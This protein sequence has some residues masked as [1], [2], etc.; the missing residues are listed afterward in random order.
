MFIS[1]QLC[2]QDLVNFH[3]IINPIQ[4]WVVNLN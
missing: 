1:F 2:N 3:I 4:N